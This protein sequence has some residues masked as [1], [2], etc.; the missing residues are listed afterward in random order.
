PRPKSCTVV[1]SPGSRT[2]ITPILSPARQ[3]ALLK[4]ARI[5]RDLRWTGGSIHRGPRG[6]FSQ[7]CVP[8]NAIRPAWQ[9]DTHPFDFQ[10]YPRFPPEL[11]A[12]EKP[13]VASRVLPAIPRDR[14]IRGQTPKNKPDTRSKNAARS[15]EP[16]SFHG[17]C[18]LRLNPGQT[19]RHNK[20]EFRPAAPQ[21]VF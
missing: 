9:T 2:W 11:F 18:K 7:A 1:K 13:A 3:I 4:S 8:A 5:A 10:R 19:L 21:E 14:R 20:R 17:I 15:R 12:A 6:T 16:R